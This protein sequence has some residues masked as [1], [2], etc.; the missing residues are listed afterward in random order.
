MSSRVEDRHLSWASWAPA[1]AA[2]SRALAPRHDIDRVP[3]VTTQAV[4]AQVVSAPGVSAQA[5]SA[6]GAAATGQPPRM[7]SYVREVSRGRLDGPSPSSSGSVGS[8]NVGSSGGAQSH[9]RPVSS[10][11]FRFSS[12]ANTSRYRDEAEDAPR[13]LQLT[14]CLA[15]TARFQCGSQIQHIRPATIAWSVPSL[16]FQFVDSSS[17]YDAWVA[18]VDGSVVERLGIGMHQ[19]Q[20]AGLARLLTVP[21]SDRLAAQF[22]YLASLDTQG[23]QFGVG[24]EYLVLSAWAEQHRATRVDELLDVHP[25]VERAAQ[26]LREQPEQGSLRELAKACGASASWLS[27]LFREQLGVSLVGYRN[28]ARIDRFF[29]LYREGRGLNLSDAALGAGF[30]SYAQFHRVFKDTLGF[31]P[32]DLK[33]GVRGALESVRP[34]AN[35]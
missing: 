24:L 31:A 26:L 17:D 35:E 2:M 9:V 30:G 18:D 16:R 28:Q 23:E 25:V 29:E 32:G 14:L 34:T 20:G 27:R 33:R 7:E 11:V 22:G 15:G 1:S 12:Q 10:R 6:N 3:G 19:R 13:H 8:G 5:V 21:S 4:S